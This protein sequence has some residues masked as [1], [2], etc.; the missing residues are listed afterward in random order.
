MPSYEERA[1]TL[2]SNLTPYPTLEGSKIISQ[3]AKEYKIVEDGSVVVEVTGEEDDLDSCSDSRLH[4]SNR[5][6]A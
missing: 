5:N 1:P 3:N 2:V 4:L 6:S